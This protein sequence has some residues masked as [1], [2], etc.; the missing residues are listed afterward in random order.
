MN[1]Y[2]RDLVNHARE[3]EAVIQVPYSGSRQ[4]YSFP[5]LL[6]LKA[7]PPLLKQIAPF[8]KKKQRTNN[9]VT[10]ERNRGNHGYV[11]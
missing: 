4:S 3:K 8:S 9:A 6:T 5:D 7:M 2:W 11:L 1:P 10:E